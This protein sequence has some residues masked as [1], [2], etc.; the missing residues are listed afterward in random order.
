LKK[1]KQYRLSEEAIQLL[2]QIAKKNGLTNTGAL[3]ML[4]REG[5]EKRAIINKQ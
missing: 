5:A 1:P 4:I 3:E 2:A